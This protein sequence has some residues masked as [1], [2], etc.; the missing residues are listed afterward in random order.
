VDITQTSSTITVNDIVEIR[1]TANDVIESIR[2][3]KGSLSETTLS[4]NIRAGSSQTLIGAI[5]EI[6]VEDPDDMYVVIKDIHIPGDLGAASPT[7]SNQIEVAQIN[8]LFIGGDWYADV[9]VDNQFDTTLGSLLAVTLSGDWF[10]GGLWQN[11]KAIGTITISG[12]ILASALNP[13]EI[14]AGSASGSG[15]I[16]TITA[17]SIQNARIGSNTLGFANN[18]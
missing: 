4:I 12:S 11:V 3:H 16:N 15:S 1:G 5:E 18:S 17:T 7:G 10:S 8:N 9:I 14:W 13:V 6:W 2:V